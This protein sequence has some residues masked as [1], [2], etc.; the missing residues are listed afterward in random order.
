MAGVIWCK[1]RNGGGGC[2]GEGGGRGWNTVC[3]C[4]SVKA[5]VKDLGIGS[6]AF[7]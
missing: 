7:P 5:Q 3:I 1:G 6:E 2:I 4:W